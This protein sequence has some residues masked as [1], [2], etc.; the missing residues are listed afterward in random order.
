MLGDLRYAFR[1]FAKH[2]GYSAVALATLALGIGVNTTMFSVLNALVLRS[3]G[4]RDS[5]RLVNIFRSSP[6]SQEW[7]TSPAN[8]LDYSAQQKSFQAL[9]AYNNASYNLAEPG[10][11][12]QHLA[13]M[14]FSG[15]AFQM[16]GVVPEVGRTFGPEYDQPGHGEVALLTDAF[17]RS[18]Y[19]ADPSV[20]GRQIRLDTVPVT[21]VGV[22]PPYFEQP[23]SWG[24]LDVIRPLGWNAGTR[25][26][27]D[28]NWLGIL[29]RLKP[30][31]TLEAAQSEAS[32]IASRLAHDFPQNNEGIG[33]HLVP[34]DRV[35][36][37]DINRRISWLCMILAGFVLLIACANLAN[38]QLARTSARSRELAVR[39]A[40]GASRLQVVRQLLIESVL[41]SAAGGA[42][43]VLLASWGVKMIAGSIYI[44]G[45]WGFDIPINTAVLMFTLAASVAAGVVSGTVPA[46]LASR[47]DVNSALKQ[48]SRGSTGDRSRH[49]VR[50]VLI[51]SELAL[52]LV[53]LSG[54]SYF[55]RGMQ[56]LSHADEGWKPDGLVVGTV[57]LPYNSRYQTDA[58]CQ[59]FFHSLEQKLSELPGAQGETVA[60][61]LPITGFWRSNGVIIQGKARPPHGKEP[62][63]YSNFVS[64]GHFGVMGMRLLQGR[65][66]TDADRAGSVKVAV[67]NET[68]ARVLF[69]GEDP[70]GKRISGTD[71]TPEWYEVV[72]VVNDVRP[73]LDIV[74]PPD[75]PFQVYK[76]ID[77]VPWSFLHY[78]NIAVRTTAPAASVAGA[79]R[80]AVQQIDPDQPVSDISTAREAIRAQVTTGFTLVAK[81]LGCF[82]LIGLVLASVGLYGVISFLTAQRTPEIGI[83][84]A[85]G[86]QPKQVLWLILGQG[87]RL[88]A[89]G[90]A[91][92]L[93]GSWAVVKGADAVLPMF[94]GRDPLLIVVV[95]VVLSA[96]AV[97]ACLVPARSAMK[98]DP[99][100]ALRAE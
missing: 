86:A 9:A 88:A 99:I 16:L 55:V 20:V 91:I 31:V 12:A 74:R 43:G 67:I 1:Q 64:P 90:S 26:T 51:V 59:A 97:A 53:L 40:V 50:K 70:I 24:H 87:V 44:T 61:N 83:R 96:V 39:V 58:Q 78:M 84:M 5:G 68:M 25:Q 45:V 37:G 28:N 7:P 41:L 13:G 92:G 22:L 11:P 48:G 75:T 30:G 14:V 21:V 76:P 4:F 79:M 72:G 89:V 3:S 60:T 82:A 85:L 62:L 66:F 65:G 36:T 69:P 54:A 18:H 98:I 29:G 2:P 23:T 33:I 6:Q 46:W 49:L 35:R 34:W 15:A 73:Y 27:R 71:P 32:A 77:Q 63:V 19:A 100:I 10:Q 42:L 95:A 56:R 38:L 57:T 93:L 52:A 81:I 94:P 8:F 80:V 17:W 47:A